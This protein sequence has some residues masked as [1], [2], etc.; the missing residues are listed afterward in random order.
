MKGATRHHRYLTI[1]LSLCMALAPVL[2]FIVNPILGFVILACVLVA[3]AVALHSVRAQAE[4]PARTLLTLL[5]AVNLLLAVACL[6]AAAWLAT[7]P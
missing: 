7:R 3:T 5:I 1:A 4:P 6:L 2:G